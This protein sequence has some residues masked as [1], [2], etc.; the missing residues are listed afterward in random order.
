MIEYEIKAA[1]EALTSLPA[2][3]LLLPDPE[4][5]GVTYQK[6]SN[7]KVDTG[8]ASTALVQG[9]FQVALYVIDDYA[10]L[11]ELDKA[12]C[13]AWES[14]QHG[15]IGRWPVQTVTRGTMQQGATTLTNNGVQYRLVRDYVICYPED[16]T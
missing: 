10:R 11:I 6:V 8:L 14:I 9:R 2:Y 7:P 1:L 15:H 3:P 16:A 5:E 4:Q 12:I 13:D